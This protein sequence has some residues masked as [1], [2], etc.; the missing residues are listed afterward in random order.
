MFG[1]LKRNREPRGHYGWTDTPKWQFWRKPP[2]RKLEEAFNQAFGDVDLAAVDSSPRIRGQSLIRLVPIVQSFE[3]NGRK[4]TISCLEIYE[5]GVY[6]MYQAPTHG[7]LDQL[8]SFWSRCYFTMEDDMGNV[9]RP[10]GGGGSGDDSRMRWEAGFVPA[11]AV[12]AR[13]VV[14]RAFAT[15][16]P[17]GVAPAAS[18][19]EPLFAATVTL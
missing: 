8:T 16:N 7:T 12:N 3:S 17:L 13:A 4:L 18:S 10:V 11:I 5:D 9:Y 1:W 2:R 6:L 15:R 19:S 14:I